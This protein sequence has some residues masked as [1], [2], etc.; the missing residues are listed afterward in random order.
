MI[1]LT[2]DELKALIQARDV[3]RQKS[4]R[5]ETGGGLAL[6]VHD[7]LVLYL[8]ACVMS[9]GQAVEAE[10]D[11]VGSPAPT[12]EWPAEFSVGGPPPDPQKLPGVSFKPK[13]PTDPKAGGPW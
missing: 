13:H 3:L 6:A 11:S 2:P 7:G 12:T 9:D 5:P 10:G 1:E 4:S 8:K